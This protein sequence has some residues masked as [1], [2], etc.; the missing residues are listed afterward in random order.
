MILNARYYKKKYIYINQHFSGSDEPITLFFLF[1]NVKMPTIVGILTFMSRIKF[2]LSC[3]SAQHEK[4]FITLGFVLSQS[5]HSILSIVP[6][7][8]I[9]PSRYHQ[10]NFA[11]YKGAKVTEKIKRWPADLAVPGLIPTRGDNLFN[12]K[13]GSIAHCS[14]TKCLRP[15]RG[16]TQP[17]FTIYS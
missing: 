2:M 8:I 13:R 5:M 15:K 1:I 10:A 6:Q 16:I 4:K 9:G 7:S 3:S 14:Y 11:Y 17:K 12:P